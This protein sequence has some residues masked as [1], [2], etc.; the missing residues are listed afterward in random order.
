MAAIIGPMCV[1]VEYFVDGEPVTIYVTQRDARLPVRLRGGRI[2]LV[3]WG[4]REGVPGVEDDTGP[5]HIKTWPSG[6]WAPLDDVRADKW[7]RYDPKPV[8]IAINRFV[9]VDKW[10]V[11]R[12]TYLTHGQYLQGLLAEAGRERRV[13]VVTV[14]S[15]ERLPGVIWPRIITNTR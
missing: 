6:G 15:P 1:G 14:H 11:P 7:R 4:A 5:G 13:Y 8:K 2:K 3:T 12:W 10:H 9:V